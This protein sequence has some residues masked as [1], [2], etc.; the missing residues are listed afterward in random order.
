MRITEFCNKLHIE[1]PDEIREYVDTSTLTPE[2]YREYYLEIAKFIKNKLQLEVNN[3]NAFYSGKIKSLISNDK[4]ILYL[5]AVDLTELMQTLCFKLLFKNTPAYKEILS[6]HKN[7]NMDWEEVMK[8]LLNRKLNNILA[9]LSTICEE[10]DLGKHY[11]E[12]KH[13]I[14]QYVTM[15][16]NKRITIRKINT[17]TNESREEYDRLRNVLIQ[18]N[19]EFQNSKYAKIGI[20]DIFVEKIGNGNE[21]NLLFTYSE[22]ISTFSHDIKYLSSQPL[23]AQKLHKLF[24]EYQIGD[25]LQKKIYGKVYNSI[26]CI[27][28]PVIKELLSLPEEE[29]IETDPLQVI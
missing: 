10:G 25:V 15:F 16:I 17:I 7:N 13:K 26:F 3:K 29:E 28:Y 21:Y 2:K 22:Y 19:F 27:F 20:H 11:S 5:D 14:Y 9:Q 18:G 6:M 24:E 4:L 8:S 12:R 1:L 23:S